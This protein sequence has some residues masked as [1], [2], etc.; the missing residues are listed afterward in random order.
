MMAKTT[1][2]HI[3]TGNHST[4]QRALDKLTKAG[5][6]AYAEAACGAWLVLAVYDEDGDAARRVVAS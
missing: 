1:G 3:L 5:I 6:A 4:A 2:R